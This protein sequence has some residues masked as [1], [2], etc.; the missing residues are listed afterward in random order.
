MN[1]D[2]PIKHRKSNL[3][4]HEIIPLIEH[5]NFLIIHFLI[6]KHKRRNISFKDIQII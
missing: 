3:G 6:K 5:Y 1:Q 4:D 2:F